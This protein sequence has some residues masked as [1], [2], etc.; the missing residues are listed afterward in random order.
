MGQ[1]PSADIDESNMSKKGSKDS[2]DR[3]Q[4]KSGKSSSSATKSATSSSASSKQKPYQKAAAAKGAQDPVASTPATAADKLKIPAQVAHLPRI[5]PEDLLSVD[6]YHD[7]AKRKLPKMVY[8]YY[9]SGADDMIT[10]Q[11]SVDAFRRIKLRPRMFVDVTPEKLQLSTTILGSKVDFPILVAPSAMHKM[12][13]EDGESATVRAAASMNT[14]MT[15]SSLATSTLEEV[16]QAAPDSMRWFQ[17]YI[18]KDRE[19]TRSLVSRAEKSGYRAL[20]LTVDAPRLGNREPDKINKFHLP[21]GLN[22]ALL[23]SEL[24]KVDSKKGIT[25]ESALNDYFANNL[26]ASLTWKDIAW[27]KS[28]TT[29]P[30]VVK[31]ILT[32]EDAILAVKHGVAGIIVS[33]HGARQVDTSITSIEALP[34]VMNAVRALNPQVEVYMDGGIRRGTDVL[35]ALALGARAVFVA[36]P[37]LWGLA[38]NGEAG[39]KHVLQILRRELELAMVLCG[40][41]TLGDVKLPLLW[42]P[43]KRPF[44]IAKATEEELLSKL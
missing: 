41:P 11:E 43:P 29:L 38:V 21:K 19:L 18:T 12:A 22:L 7:V 4:S 14:L 16:A 1:Q 31:G 6:M 33:T 32:E 30:I 15:L 40:C 3:K 5:A 28:I 37:V 39:V 9:R 34:E 27:L 36:R 35:K 42:N 8:D 24:S 25:N 26:D 23:N 44:D 2:D 10:L 20:V 13:H 17:L